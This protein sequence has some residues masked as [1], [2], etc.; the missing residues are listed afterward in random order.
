MNLFKNIK[1]INKDNCKHVFEILREASA[2]T[3]SGHG[4]EIHTA[5]SKCKKCNSILETSTAILYAAYQDQ[6]K[7]TNILA[8]T[9]IISFTTL[10]LVV[11]GLCLD[12]INR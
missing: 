11:I 12:Y 1:Q 4:G 5:V 2:N 3:D 7:A 8:I 6:A 9:T 10:I